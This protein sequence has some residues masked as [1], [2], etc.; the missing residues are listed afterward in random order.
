[1][2]E[3][4]ARYLPSGLAVEHVQERGK[5]A[6]VIIDRANS[7]PTHLIAMT[8]HGLS[9]IRRWL[10]GS[11]ASRVVHS[12]VNPV[13]L[14]RT[15][16]EPPAEIRL[17]RVLV[18][19]DGSALAERILPHLVTLANK[20]KLET[21]LLRVYDLPAA[22]YPM[23]VPY[24]ESLERHREK[25]RREAEMYLAEKSAELGA[26]GL[27]RIT[28]TVVQ[29]DPASEIIDLARGTPDN[30]IAMS[31]HGRSGVG[32]VLLGSVA[33][34]VVHH[35]QDPVLIIRPSE[36]TTGGH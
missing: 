7:D 1:L 10:L 19:L 25:E 9:G 32:R 11:V 30:L 2:Q 13:L 27:E 16:N 36:G 20:L 22:A 33:E 23:D 8:T 12:T 5:P 17:K 4:A 29:G 28:P 31:S 35:S 26:Q 15:V 24:L 34:K 21:E 14:I 3:A 18:P 6:Q